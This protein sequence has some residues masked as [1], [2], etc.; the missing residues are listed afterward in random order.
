MII[1]LIS[2]RIRLVIWCLSWSYYVNHVQYYLIS[3]LDLIPRLLKLSSNSFPICSAFTIA[4]MSFLNKESVDLIVTSSLLF[5]INNQRYERELQQH[6]YIVT[7]LI[8]IDCCWW[9]RNDDNKY[10]DSYYNFKTKDWI[11]HQHEIKPDLS[12]KFWVSTT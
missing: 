10:I 5:I 6:T 11:S 12:G 4:L 3:Y 2:S 8:T 7:Q 9:K 1:S